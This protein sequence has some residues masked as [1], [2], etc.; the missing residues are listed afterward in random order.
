MMMNGK[1]RRR[2]YGRGKGKMPAT[3]CPRV[4]H[5]HQ[6]ALPDML[7][8]D[9]SDETE[10]KGFTTEEVTQD[11]AYV[12]YIRR[13]QYGDEDIG[14]CRDGAG[15]FEETSDEEEF[16]GFTEQDL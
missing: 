2:G 12:E 4:L 1:I 5:P 14:M 9:L 6:T 8:S 3:V 13:H 11:E 7:Q 10:F 16:M 15:L